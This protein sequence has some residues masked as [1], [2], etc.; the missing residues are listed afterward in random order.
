MRTCISRQ[1]EH[2]Y[3]LSFLFVRSLTAILLVGG[4]GVEDQTCGLPEIRILICVIYFSG[5][6][7]K[8]AYHDRNQDCRIN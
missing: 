3:I 4:L 1:M 7:P 2:H 6:A 5:V 8:R